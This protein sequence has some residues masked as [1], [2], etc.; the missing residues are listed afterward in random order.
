M[1]VEEVENANGAEK[2]LQWPND[3]SVERSQERHVEPLL[4]RDKAVWE[5]P[6][7][8]EYAIAVACNL[9]EQTEEGDEE[10]KRYCAF[11]FTREHF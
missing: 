8:Q 5:L 6:K 4:I 2:V 1:L 9:F 7:K 11:L 3:Q 10:D